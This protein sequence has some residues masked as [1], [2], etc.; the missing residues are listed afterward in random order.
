MALITISYTLGNKRKKCWKFNNKAFLYQQKKITKLVGELFLMD[1][2]Y[3]YYI[4]LI[5]F[6]PNNN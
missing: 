6:I 4:S 1:I 5:L 2:P 3:K